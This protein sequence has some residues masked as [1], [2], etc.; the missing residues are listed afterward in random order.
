LIVFCALSLQQRWLVLIRD[1]RSGGLLGVYNYFRLPIDAVPDIT[2]VQVQINTE[3]P[4]YSPLEAEQRVTLAAGS[5]CWAGCHGCRT[6]ARCHA[7][8]CR[9]SRWCSR[10]GQTFTF[11]RQLVSERLQAARN[12]L[13]S[14]LDPVLGPI[15]TGL[16]E[17]SQWTVEAEPGTRK[18]DGSP[19]D[20]TDLRTLQDWVV[21]PQL[22]TL[23][24]VTEINSIGGFQKQYLVAP[25][26]EKLASYGLSIADVMAA[27]ARN[28][29]NVGAGYIERRGEQYLIR[30]P[31]QVQS[32]DDLRAIVIKTDDSVPVY[33]RD[34]ADIAFGRELRTG[35][36]T[37]NG[38][39]VVLGT[40][41]MLI[42][43]NSRTV[44]E[45]VKQKLAEVQKSLPEGVQAVLVYDRTKLVDATIA[46]VQ[47][48]LL[49]G[50]LLVIAV[51]FAFL[52]N[53][54]RSPDYGCRDPA[55]HADDDHG[56]G[57]PTR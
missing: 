8:D 11:A 26:P 17:I 27:L 52:G 14:G 31:G 1:T 15:S 9:R 7:T 44:A 53:Y 32:L 4:G 3:A 25:Y 2:N 5:R 43:E 48:N 45:R 29:A 36:A 41:F 47:K 13:P 56:H 23:P 22:R 12:Q 18:A 24:G 38:R 37:E 16:G 42:G 10:K 30:A 28:N 54:P 35:A 51:L 46:T 21:K 20:T 55:G 57:E 50:A 49:E 39:E 6:V 33:L 40:A 34:V 19:Y